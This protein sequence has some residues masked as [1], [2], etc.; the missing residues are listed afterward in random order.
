MTTLSGR[1]GELRF[2]PGLPTVL[3]ND[4]L[5]IMDQKPG[6]L[7]ELKAGR[8]DALLELARSGHAAGLDMVDILI[9]H[10]DLD[11]V[12]LLPRIAAAVHDEIGC[13]IALD[14]RN[15]AA[16][17]AALEAL[18]PHKALINSITAETESIEALMPLAKRY[19]AAVVAMPIGHTH[20]LPKTIAGRL[21]ELEV[22]LAAADR[23][24]IPREDIVVDTICLASSAEPGSMRVTLDTTQAISEMG[25]ATILGIG[26]AG[27]GMPQ[28]TVI[29]LAYLVAAIPWGLDVALVD[30]TTTGLVE[31][32]RAV[33]FLTGNDE[34]GKRYIARYREQR[35]R[36]L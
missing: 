24:G 13:P 14:S 20:G 23:Y 22:F 34:Y 16:L 10:T 2:G 31:T 8:F 5:R 21:A 15:P 28:Q 4:Q 30:P 17:E 27:F 11:E 9:N 3:I 18:Q 1:S 35:K 33:D 6:V 29:D 36:K 26:N 12:A 32:V 19:G 25:L 7:A